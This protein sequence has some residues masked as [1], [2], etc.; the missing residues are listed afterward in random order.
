MSIEAQ[1]EAAEQFVRGVVERFGLEGTT[2]S[3]IG[4]DSVRINVDGDNLGILIGPR[5]AT[6]DALQEL[7]RTAVQRRSDEGSVRLVVDVGAYRARR[8]AALQQFATRIAREVIETGEPQALDPMSAADRKIV[9]DAVN[10]IEGVKTTSE[11]D[12]PQ[13][14]VVIRPA[15]PAS[16]ESD[17]S[18]SSD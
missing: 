16:P 18:G 15:A 4:E 1:A 3:E 11:G 8:A 2:S 9:H 10:E 12:D 5:G 17:D 13:R 6:L 7:T 14:Y